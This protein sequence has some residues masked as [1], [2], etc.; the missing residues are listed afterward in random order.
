MQIK[1]I[2]KVITSLSSLIEDKSIQ[3]E[4][5]GLDIKKF[6]AH[7]KVIAVKEQLKALGVTSN[8]QLRTMGFVV[9]AM[10]LRF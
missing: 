7:E 9:G 8:G 5:G 1:K 6:N 4:N 2:E 3:D 10:I